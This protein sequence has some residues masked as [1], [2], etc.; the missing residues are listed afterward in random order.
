MIEARPE[1]DPADTDTDSAA[2][3]ERILQL[4][5]NLVFPEIEQFP[6]SLPVPK[7]LKSPPVTIPPVTESPENEP[8]VIKLFTERELPTRV[9]DKTDNPE[10]TWKFELPDSA[11]A[12]RAVPEADIEP[13]NPDDVESVQAVAEEEIDRLL[14]PME[15]D[16]DMESPEMAA[17]TDS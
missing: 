16:T 9:F 2:I 12:T 8:A 4:S 15:R 5:L 3:A 6:L 11:P 1:T 14:P 10:P 7:T 13:L 17:D